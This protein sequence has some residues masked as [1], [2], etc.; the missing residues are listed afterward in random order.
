MTTRRPWH[1]PIPIPPASPPVSREG[2][3][4]LVRASQERYERRVAS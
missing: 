4:R 1:V 2:V 3:A